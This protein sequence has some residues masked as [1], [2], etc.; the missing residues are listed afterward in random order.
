MLF[1]KV[2]PFCSA[3]FALPNWNAFLKHS[4]LEGLGLFAKGTRARA[5]GE[6]GGQGSAA[7][8]EAHLP[9]KALP[10]SSGSKKEPGRERGGGESAELGVGR[11]VTSQSRFY[12]DHFQRWA[13]QSPPPRAGFTSPLTPLPGHRDVL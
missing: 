7:P 5:G 8:P 1:C 12:A 9:W 6:S 13:P 2:L 3:V 4:S 11:Q 10:E